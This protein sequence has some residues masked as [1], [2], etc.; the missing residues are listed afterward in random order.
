MKTFDIDPREVEDALVTIAK[1]TPLCV[2]IGR[3]IAALRSGDTVVIQ[4]E[5]RD[6]W[7]VD[8]D[9][10]GSYVQIGDQWVYDQW[11]WRIPTGHLAG[12]DLP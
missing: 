6:I 3:P 1:H 12:Y 11:R 10:V 2:E 8:T 5:D 9:T 4:N 7:L